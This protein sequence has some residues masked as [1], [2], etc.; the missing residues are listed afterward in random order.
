[1]KTYIAKNGAKYKKL[2]NG[3]VR[4]VSGASKEYLDKIRSKRS[5]SKG[6]FT[7]SINKK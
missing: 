4:F 7:S 6:I 2:S 5:I 1:M 3:Q